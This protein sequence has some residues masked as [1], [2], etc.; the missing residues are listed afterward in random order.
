[1]SGLCVDLRHWQT[2]NFGHEQSYDAESQF[3]S[4]RSR[5]RC[6]RAARWFPM[7][8]H[9]AGLQI[10]QYVIHDSRTGERN[11]ELRFL[12]NLYFCT[13]FEQR[14]FPGGTLPA[15]S[16]RRIKLPDEFADPLSGSLHFVSERSQYVADG[17]NGAPLGVRKM[18]ISRL[19]GCPGFTDHWYWFG[20]EKCG[21]T[22]WPVDGNT[23]FAAS[24][25]NTK[26]RPGNVGQGNRE[27][28]H[29]AE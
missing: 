7:D 21:A 11:R 22:N 23:E 18:N 3:A 19:V 16:N 17:S 24:A 15:K 29:S 6:S 12:S 13:Q 10:F 5:R 8:A 14:M 2:A 4:R 9:S 25:I 27:G 26:G 20:A 28:W 1:M